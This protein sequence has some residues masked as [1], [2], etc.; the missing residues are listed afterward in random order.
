MLITKLW[1]AMLM[2][3][4]ILMFG[5]TGERGPKGP[6]GPVGPE[7]QQGPVGSQGPD[8]EQGD[9]GERGEQGVQGPVGEQGPTGEA[10]PVGGL[11]EGLSPLGKLVYGLGGEETLSAVTGLSY[12][13]TGVSSIAGEG[14]NTEDISDINFSSKTVH[15]NLSEDALRVD[16]LSTALFFGFEQSFTFIFQGDV[17][18]GEGFE[19]AFGYPVNTD[20]PSDRVGSY[21]LHHSILNPLSVIMGLDESS[22]TEEIDLL[23]GVPHHVLT[24]GE[25]PTAWHMYVNASNGQLSKITTMAAEPLFCDVHVEVHYLDWMTSDQG[26]RFPELVLMTVDG[27]IVYEEHRDA[28]EVNPTFEADAF[29]YPEGAA[30]MYLEADYERGEHWF[31]F[32][33]GFASLGVPLEGLQTYIMATELS[34]G[35]HLMGGG[36]HNSLVVEQENGLVLFDAP[37]Y[38]ERVEAI[39]AWAAT[40]YP[41]KDFTHLVISHHH[42]DHV[43]GVRQLIADGATVIVSEHT[44]E[45]F[46]GIATASC[47][48]RPDAL[49]MNPLP[50]NFVTVADGE[51]VT[52]ADDTNPITIYHANSY[53]AGDMLFPFVSSVG[54]LFLVD[55]YSP[56]LNPYPPFAEQAR[57]EFTRLGLTVQQIAGGHGYVH[58]L[59]QF[60]SCLADPNT[61]GG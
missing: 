12:S 21:R 26:L 32:L 27:E 31:P 1:S 13:T 15:A 36:S 48:V 23:D 3:T 11:P 58:S 50:A 29:E 8:G 61:C 35:V 19:S 59:E 24:Y 28:L 9:Q 52:L 2:Y 51:P 49:A 14:Y 10:G 54:V 39:K 44:A 16:H 30:P 55:I 41:G 53:H 37:L 7:G 34:P 22:L 5:C 38:P 46:A 20:I 43:G 17:G 60:N 45:Y 18:V 56:G 6:E 4:L 57:D 47:A 42:S 40:T 25:G 33:E